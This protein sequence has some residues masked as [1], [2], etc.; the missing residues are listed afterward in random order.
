[1]AGE[2]PT[3]TLTV[4]LETSGVQAGVTKATASVKNIAAEADK[5]SAKFNDL[6][7]IMV[8][9]FAGNQLTKGLQSLEGFLK[10]SISVASEAQNSIAEL[11]TAMNNAKINTEGNRQA[12]DKVTESMMNL[13]FTGNS[14]REAL[15]KMVTATGSMSQAQKLMGVAADYAR[16]KHM[17]LNAAASILTRGTVGA[18]RAFREYGIVLDTNL[19]KNEAITKAFTQLNEKIGGQAQT[20]AQTYAGK[21]EI[22]GVKSNDLKEKI[23]TLLLPVLIKLSTWF[24][25]SLNFIVKHK[26]IMQ[27]LAVLLGSVVT[28]VVV[29]L[30]KQLFLQA[31]AW[32][33]VNAELLIIVASVAAVA[34]GFIYAWNKSDVFRHGVVTAIEAILDSVS[35]LLRAIGFIAEAFLQVVTG[36]MRLMLKGLGFFVPAAKT[37]SEEIGKMPKA[38]GDFFDGAATKVSSFKKTLESVKDT[39]VNIALPDFSKMLA[40]AGGKAGVD[41]GILGLTPENTAGAQKKANAIK[42][43]QD[44]LTKLYDK[45]A[46]I[47]KDRQDKMDLAQSDYDTKALDARTKFDQA[48]AD[49]D[50]K[51]QDSVEAATTTHNEAIKNATQNHQDNLVKIQQDSVDKQKSIIQQSIDVMTSGFAT[52]TKFDL[53]RLFSPTGTTSGLIGAMQYQLKQILQLQKDAGDLAAK[54]YSQSFINQVI[55]QGPMV[56]DQMSQA[57][58]N[59]TPETAN[60][61]KSLYAEID[62]VSNSGLDKLATTMNDGTTFATT[63]MAKQYAQV[64]VDLQKSLA[65]ENSKYQD[66][67]KT[68]QIAFDKAMTTAGNARDL[69][70]KVA[71]DSLTNSL[72]AAQQ[73]FDKSIKAISDSSMKALDALM[74]KMAAAAAALAKLGGAKVAAPVSVGPYSSA[75]TGYISGGELTGLSMLQTPSSQGSGVTINAPISVDGSTSPAQIQNSL[76][77]LAKYGYQTGR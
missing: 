24:I 42:K 76:L 28:V 3:L 65:D 32:L 39:K 2:I 69:A 56:G 16:L 31:A 44:A 77:M 47:L 9:T 40:T 62:T 30:T 66:S 49:I 72:T 58:L 12:V 52:V 67:L 36:P 29:N 5:A 59:A 71:Q 21:L 54:G 26:E 57:I 68:S 23:G 1:M 74:L 19:P 60:Q 4:N 20:E 64:A 14:T 15:T 55:A 18:V 8:G 11:G 53:A 70:L 51:Y 61:I 50:I 48:K 45:Q 75:P 33:A 34:V 37:A 27:A 13:G 10:S 73:A 35:F 6:K 41:P 43:A 46:Q 63:A 25:N 38:V 7:T 22:L 17:D